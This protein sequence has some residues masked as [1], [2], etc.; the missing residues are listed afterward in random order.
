MIGC[1]AEGEVRIV[2]A[3]LD[4]LYDSLG[5]AQMHDCLQACVILI[6]VYVHVSLLEPIGD[7]PSGRFVLR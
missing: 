6:K 3:V 5:L 4:A 7:F 1:Y 2:Q